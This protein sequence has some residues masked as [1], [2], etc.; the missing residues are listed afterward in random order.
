MRP[1][2]LVAAAA[3]L[4]A[5]T[6]S[7]AAPPQPVASKVAFVLTGGGWG[8]G[9]GMSPWGAYGQSLGGRSY[10]E[11]LATYYP[12][13]SPGTTARQ[14][15]RV[16]VV[17]RATKLR[18]ASTVPFRVR[19][20]SGAVAELPAGELVLGPG[21]VLAVDGERRALPGPLV[22]KPGTGAPL[23]VGG[24]GYRGEL[25]VTSDG[26]ALQVVNVVGLESYLLGVVPG[27]MPADWPLEALKAQ[28]VAARTYALARLVEDKE[29]DLYSDGRSQIYYGTGSEAPGTT[30][31]VSE[32]RGRI[33]TFA[34]KPAL[35]LYFS[36]SGGR[37][38]SALDAFGL[39]L[40]YLEAVKDPWD[41]VETNPNHRWLPSLLTGKQLMA[42]LKLESRVTDAV[43]E[44][45]TDGRPTAVRFTTARGI[46][47]AVAASDL[48]TLLGLRSTSFRLGV[49]Q[50]FAPRVPAAAGGAVPL[51]GIA[52]DVD[53]PLL[54]R[55]ELDGTWVP[56]KRIV[57]R[58]D[59]TFSVRVRPTTTS[60]YR[61]TGAGLP[62]PTLMLAVAGAPA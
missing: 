7:P 21:L 44:R 23:S 48:R 1:I 34:G 40:P 45:G 32:T 30:K 52:R 38:R 18:L 58:A 8:H 39:D 41:A 9:V 14:K 10:T 27:E 13:T 28:A 12:G 49:L 54:E 31:A 43:T 2:L 47:S 57:P 17:P 61:L 19:D 16:L 6:A 15:V 60:T 46:E 59:G 4:T 26:K 20:A 25:R 33:L 29:F 62:G 22:V 35:T 51:S 50:L 36:S 11:I 37:T 55:R 56:A 3:A 24:K 5:G 42:A 53:D